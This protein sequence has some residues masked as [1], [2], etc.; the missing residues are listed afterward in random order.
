MSVSYLIEFAVLP[1]ERERFLLLLNGVLDA[2]SVEDKFVN[3]TLHADPED[4]NRFLLHETWLDHGD[5][6]DLQLHKPYRQA[7][8]EALPTLL[9]R[10]R[11]VSMWT[12]LRSDQSSHRG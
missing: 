5:V 12:P 7:W 3:A 6:V 2:I 10:P 4:E 1:A 11:T 8:H 9:Q